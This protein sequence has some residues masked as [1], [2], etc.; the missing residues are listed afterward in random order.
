VVA[1]IISEGVVDEWGAVNGRGLVGV[2]Q[3]VKQCPHQ[4]C[5]YILVT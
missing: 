5:T 1:A 4:V 3:G 2:I